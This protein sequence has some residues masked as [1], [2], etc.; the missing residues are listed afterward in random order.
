MKTI[1]TTLL[2][3]ISSVIYG[4]T[5]D[6]MYVPNDRSIVVTYNNNYN[7]LGF[8]VGGYITTSFPQPYMYTTPQSR[9]NRVGVS[10]SFNNKISVMGGTYL[11][12]FLNEI[13]FQP[14]VWVKI[15]PLRIL[16]DVERGPD[17]TLGVNY[18]NGINYGIGLSIP[19]R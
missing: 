11:E 15:Y 9:F 14:D 6:V 7:G 5:S 19:F 13:N 2:L 18:M 3:L 12:N 8:Y 1:V 10:L 4:Q 16:L 17:F